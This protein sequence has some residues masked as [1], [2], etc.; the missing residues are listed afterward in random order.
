MAEGDLQGTRVYSEIVPP[1]VN[2]PFGVA[3]CNRLVGGHHV[4][5][6]IE[7]RDAIKPWLRVLGMLCSVGTVDVYVTYRLEVTIENS[8]WKD[9]LLT[10][11]GNV[12]V[13]QGKVATIEGKVAV[14]EQSQANGHKGYAT[15]ALLYADLTPAANTL[16]EVTNDPDTTLNGAYIKVG[17]TG[18]GSWQISSNGIYTD[19]STLKAKTVNQAVLPDSLSLTGKGPLVLAFRDSLRRVAA[20]LTAS[21]EWIS[22]HYHD[23]ATAAA[24]GFMSAVDKAWKDSMPMNV[25]AAVTVGGQELALCVRDGAG[26]VALCL[27]KDGL[28]TVSR[29][30]INSF[31]GVLNAENVT[32]GNVTADTVALDGAEVSV[33]T[34][35]PD[36]A[37]IFRDGSGKIAFA[38]KANGD[39][40]AP[41]LPIPGASPGS[42]TTELLADESVTPPK[43]ATAL[44]QQISNDQIPTMPDDIRPQDVVLGLYSGTNWQTL[45][46]DITPIIEGVNNSGTSLDFR[47]ASGLLVAGQRKIGTFDA[48]TVGPSTNY[49]GT[50]RD[51]TTW[52][53]TGT[54][55]NGDYYHYTST[56]TR[57]IGSDTLRQGD[58]MI[59]VGGAWAYK[60]NPASGATVYRKDWWEV[61]G[62][63]IYE[64]ITLAV[65]DR[66]VFATYESSGAYG[67]NRWRKGL[68]LNGECFRMGSFDPAGGLPATPAEGDLWEVSAA[69]TTGGFTLAVGDELRRKSSVWIR[70]ASGAVVTVANGAGVHLRCAYTAAEWEFRRTD[71]SLT[72]VG[73]TLAAR[74]R[75]IQR[76]SSTDIQGYADSMGDNVFP[77]LATI[78]G[79]A[80]ANRSNPGGTSD[81]IEGAAEWWTSQ[82]DPD[83]GRTM[84]TIIGQNNNSNVGQ[85]MYMRSRLTQLMGSADRR[86]LHASALGQRAMVWDAGLGRLT[87]PNF[88]QQWVEGSAN[89]YARD[90]AALRAAYPD[91]WFWSAENLCNASIGDTAPDPQFP[92]MT[93][94]QSAAAY[95]IP[96]VKYCRGITPAD[97]LDYCINHLGNW[98]SGTLPTGGSSGD[99]YKRIDG[100][101]AGRFMA[102]KNGAWTPVTYDDIHLNTAG[103][104]IQATGLNAKLVAKNI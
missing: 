102:N 59:R 51:T 75:P 86:V 91:N 69:G 8:G 77:A 92:G 30:T 85:T 36:Y 55:A 22:R 31:I 49:K 68:P 83:R 19:V 45:P 71:K 56:I 12:T 61:T 47:P 11:N 63:G 103:D 101:N 43:L 4:Y 50:L 78:S 20:G 5:A 27:G 39:I 72:R 100:A 15:R 90:V 82:G 38:I 88:E 93:Y 40:I 76:R 46:R 41:G 87:C 37:V 17:A 24:A 95:H 25:I 70:I 21:G 48:S 94:E 33:I 98:S 42:V 18:T 9:A 2:S 35:T 23:A 6:T 73:A 66:L 79:R 44:V 80:V 97:G 99:Y 58:L 7:E 1:N 13:L 74:G 54:F 26:K 29:A 67:F 60:A 34:N 10:V 89:N 3:N 28:L 81:E 104:T 16:A 32:A 52:P 57:V 65:G 84:I 14:L 96:A 64:G 62:A 53:P